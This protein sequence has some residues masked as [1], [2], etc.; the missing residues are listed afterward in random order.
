MSEAFYRKKN[1]RGVGLI[2][3]LVAV[4]LLSIG[5]LAAARMQ[6][7]GMR[8][9]QSAY[10]QSQAYFMASDMLDRMRSNVKGVTSGAYSNMDTA[11]NLLDPGCAKP[12]ANCTAMQIAEQ[13]R[14]NWSIQLYPG[15][16][17][18][19]ALPGTPKGMVRLR[20]G[21][22]GIYDVTLEWNETINGKDQVESLS[23]TFATEQ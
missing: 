10:Y 20:P 23:V 22:D 9:S 2:E 7:Q 6:V 12:A 17:V 1:Q 5:F 18:V 11:D 3:I 13:D 8:F 14:Y 21:S 15:D 16:G 19:P 4:V